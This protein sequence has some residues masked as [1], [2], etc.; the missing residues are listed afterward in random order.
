MVPTYSVSH[1]LAMTVERC[2]D[3]IQHYRYQRHRWNDD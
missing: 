3:L 2:P 1:G